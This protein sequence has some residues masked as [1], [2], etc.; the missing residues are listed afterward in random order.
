VLALALGAFSSFIWALR[1]FF[2]V[3]ST[4][5]PH[6]MRLLKYLSGVVMLTQFGLLAWPG[7]VTG[8]KTYIAVAFY[9]LALALFWRTVAVNRARP[10]RIAFTEEVPG[11]LV[12]RGPYRFVRHPF[13]TSYMLAWLAGSVATASWVLLGSC[14]LLFILYYRAARFEEGLFRRSNLA[15]AYERYRSR[16]GM[17]FPRLV[18]RHH[19][20]S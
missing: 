18:R 19:A 8:S 10:L 3:P 14:L 12:E 16:T 4:G 15:D 9:V 6:E 17:F 7:N 13:Y 2:V 20:G 5:L 11:H 1:R